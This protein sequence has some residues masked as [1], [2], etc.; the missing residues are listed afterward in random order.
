MLHTC[1]NENTTPVM[2]LT[3]TDIIAALDIKIKEARQ[4]SLKIAASGDYDGYQ[5]CRRKIINLQLIQ[6]QVK[7]DAWLQNIETEQEKKGERI[8]V[9]K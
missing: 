5:E 7:N 8:M 3:T 6:K 9:A 4:E 1:E 2:E